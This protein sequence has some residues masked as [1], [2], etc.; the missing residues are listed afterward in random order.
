MLTG[1][2]PFQAASPVDTVLLVLEQE[3]VP[4]RLLNPRADRELEMIALKC[5]QKPPEL[6]YATAAGAGRRPASLS[7]RRADR[8]PQSGCSARCMARWFRETHHATVLENWGLLWMWHSLVLLVL[9]LLTNWL[10]W[11]GETRR[12]PY[13]ALWT[14]GLGTWAG[15]L[16]GAAPAG[17]AGDVRRAADRPRLGRAA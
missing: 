1:R 8:R 4:P 14:A 10:Q 16:L 7:G 13:L 5:L 15:D 2:P 3:P 9:C 17:R 6:R 12:W 11:R